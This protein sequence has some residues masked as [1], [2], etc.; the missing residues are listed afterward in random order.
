MRVVDDRRCA[1]GSP[2]C[3]LHPG[4]IGIQCFLLGKN[5]V[6]AC[7]DVSSR[8]QPDMNLNIVNRNS[9]RS[10]AFGAVFSARIEQVKLP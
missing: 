7:G 9:Y 4:G 3:E 6:V 10:A 1:S 5:T 2:F 8:L